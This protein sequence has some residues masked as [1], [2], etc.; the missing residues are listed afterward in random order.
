MEAFL[1]TSWSV[2]IGI[3]VV[4]SG[5]AAFMTGQALA[6]TWRPFWQVLVYTVL[7]ALASRLLTFG[8]FQGELWSPSGYLIAMATLMLISAFAYRITL[9]RK[10]VAQYPWL[11]RRTGLFTWQDRT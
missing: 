8:L 3:T 4:L 1:G 2:F 10:M 9:A 7:L 6:A 11:Y 5:F